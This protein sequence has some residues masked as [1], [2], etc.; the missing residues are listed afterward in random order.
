MVAV[1][2]GYM[3]LVW[4]LSTTGAARNALPRSLEKVHNLAQAVFSAGALGVAIRELRLRRLYGDPGDVLPEADAHRDVRRGV[5]RLLPVKSR[6]D[7]RHH[8]PAQQR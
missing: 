5:V 2:A 7:A 6:R 3:V 4:V 1:N 8:V